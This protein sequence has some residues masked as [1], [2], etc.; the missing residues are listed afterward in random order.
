MAGSG[1]LTDPFIAKFAM[2]QC[3][4]I[5][6]TCLETV[7]YLNPLFKG[8]GSEHIDYTQRCGRAGFGMKDGGYVHLKT[9][10]EL[11]GIP[12]TA[13]KS[14]VAENRDLAATLKGKEIFVAPYADEEQ[15]QAL[16]AEIAPI[17]RN[18]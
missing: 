5:S 4:A 3:M 17:L 18:G 7:G 9:G 8:Y 2:G 6:R 16:E 14:G 10:M 15:R 11:L 12:P 13:D 1:T